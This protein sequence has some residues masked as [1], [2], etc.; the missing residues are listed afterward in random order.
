MK[1]IHINKMHITSHY[2][3]QKPMYMVRGYTMKLIITGLLIISVLSGCRASHR[4]NRIN[5]SNCKRY[6]PMTTSDFLFVLLHAMVEKAYAA[7]TLGYSELNILQMIKDDFQGLYVHDAI[8]ESI[9]SSIDNGLSC[10]RALLIAYANENHLKKL[11]HDIALSA[12]SSG[13]MKIIQSHG[14]AD[15]AYAI[16]I[17]NMHPQTAI[18]NTEKRM[19]EEDDAIRKLKNQI[20]IK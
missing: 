14:P 18:K 8:G 1:L 4:D 2:K 9:N 5:D 11:F 13:Q 19:I 20:N 7:Y 16:E 17:M 6:T 12:M 10:D 3:R 15:K